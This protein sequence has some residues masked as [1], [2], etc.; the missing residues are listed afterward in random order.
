MSV[1]SLLFAQLS[2]PRMR[3]VRYDDAER[4][5]VHRTILAEKPMLRQVF[6]EIYRYCRE[7]DERFFSGDGLRIELGAGVSTFKRDYPDVISTDIEP[8][9]HLDR[10]LDAQRM[11]LA[12]GSVRAI[13]GINCF[14]HFPEPERFFAELERVLV[15]GGGCVLI[16]PYYGP[17]AGAFYRNLFKTEHFNKTQSAWTG[18]DMGVM[19][20]A[21]QALSFI[22]F[23]RDRR[24]FESAFATL[25]I[26][27]E[28]PLE[29]YVRYVLS[30]GLNFRALAPFAM[31]PALKLVE[32]ALRPARPLLALHHAIVLRKRR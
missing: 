31:D 7:A 9:E 4:I 11:D 25:E 14:H 15:P 20:G 18:S 23:V 32:H 27:H 24:R 6:H 28:E 13:Y 8:A 19:S 3:H 22:V 12:D 26:V 29:N 1:L 30:G 10:V 16:E 2:E 21:N 5:N 17:L